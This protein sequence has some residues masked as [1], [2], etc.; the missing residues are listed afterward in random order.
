MRA[1]RGVAALTLAAA[2]LAAGGCTDAPVSPRKQAAAAASAAGPPET[3]ETPWR[4]RVAEAVVAPAKIGGEPVDV[5]GR[6]AVQAGYAEAAEFAAATTFDEM[7]LVPTPYR[8]KAQFLR[9]VSRMTPSMA[10]GYND[11]LDAAW[12]GDQE[13]A[14]MLFA[15][16]Y[17]FV[18]DGDGDLQETGPL[19]LDHVI[20]DPQAFV[21]RGLGRA[22]L[23]VSFVQRGDVRMVDDGEAV[24]VRYTKTATYWL[25]PAPPGDSH[26]WRI[27][28]QD[29]AWTA[30]EPVPD[31]GTY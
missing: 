20:E 18:G 7:L 10:A 3:V 17:Y 25:D 30:D 23:A 14:D 19:V 28:F 22:Q 24:L 31:T 2:L 5:F 13:A 4:H 11:L 16:R 6:Q 12:D 15:M 29:V 9:H 1:R 21:E 26:R 27:D 8:G